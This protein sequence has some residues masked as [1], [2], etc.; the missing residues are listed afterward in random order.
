M[1]NEEILKLAFAKS[2]TTEEAK[3]TAEW[4]KR[5]L[6]EDAAKLE[7]D[8][9]QVKLREQQLLNILGKPIDDPD[10]HVDTN[11]LPL[12]LNAPPKKKRAKSTG[13]CGGRAIPEEALIFVAQ[14][15]PHIKTEDEFDAMAD[16]LERSTKA[17]KEWVFR[18]FVKI[19]HILLPP[20]VFPKLYRKAVAAA[21]AKAKAETNG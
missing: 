11:R 10:F 17:I 2:S 9:Q 7:K 21:K 8:R 12:I 15:L 13:K 1:N 16:Q 3:K 20:A 4:M 18:G 5:F 14:R 19:D 6:T